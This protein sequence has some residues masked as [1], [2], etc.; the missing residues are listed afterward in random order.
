[1]NVQNTKLASPGNDSS[2]DELNACKRIFSSLLLVCKNLSLYPDGHTICINS[3]K[4]FHA[5]LR[6]FLQ[7]F[8]TLKLDIERERIVSKGVTISSGFPEEGSLHFTLFRDGIRWLEFLDEIDQEE[9]HDIL[10]IISKYAKL[11]AEPEGDIVTA[12]WEAQF[13]HMQYEVAE[14]SWDGGDQEMGDSPSS[15]TSGKEA[16]T[17]L[18]EKSL[19]GTKPPGDPAIDQ[20]SLELT[21]QEKKNLSAMIRDEQEA[22]LTSYLNALLDSLLQQQ[23]KENFTIILEVLLEEF[24]GSLTRRDFV[25]MLKILQGLQYVL[26]ICKTDLTWAGQSIEKFSLDASSMESLAPLKEVWKQINSEDAEILG[27]VFK[28]INPQA[29]STLAF[30][31]PLPQTVTQRQML[32]DSICFLSLQDIR[33]LETMLNNSDD[34]LV[35]KLIPLIVNLEGGQPMKYLMKLAR[36]PSA[37]VRQEAIKTIFKHYTPNVKDIFNLIDD[38]DDSIRQLILKQ[39]GQSRDVVAEEMLITYLQKTKFSNNEGSHVILCFRTLGECGS[40][41]SVPFLRETLLRYGWMPGRW[42]SAHRSGAAIA[43]GTLGIPEAE[44]VLKKA[45]RSLYPGLRGIVKKVRQEI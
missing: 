39:L 42:R 27:Q 21:P 44:T 12:F 45:G 32:V 35:E 10:I 29:I 5:L 3:I 43:L 2:A 7:K 19:E 16:G 11:T 40:L 15:L 36:H 23:E 22:D 25:V 26:D 9:I 33:Y 18:R 34:K 13:P 6:N 37:R 24:R 14:F 30:L 38:K 1:M 20:A 4:Q 8:K 17:Q 41:G 28:L 31:L